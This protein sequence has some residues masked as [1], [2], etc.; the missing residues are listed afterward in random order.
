MKDLL[1]GFP[2]VTKSSRRNV[3]LMYNLDCEGDHPLNETV[4]HLDIHSHAK[5]YK[6][7]MLSYYGTPLRSMIKLCTMDTVSECKETC[8]LSF[9]LINNI[10]VYEDE[11]GISPIHII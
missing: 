7:Y 2:F 5:G 3:E 9:K 8:E 10:H 6:T 11:K 4:V 1:Y